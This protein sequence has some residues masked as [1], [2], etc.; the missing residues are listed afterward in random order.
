MIEG[1]RSI[2]N[3]GEHTVVGGHLT[4]GDEVIQFLTVK[5]DGLNFVGVLL[6]AVLGSDVE[7][8]YDAV[9]EFSVYSGVGD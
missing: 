3:E 2:H 7:R 5:V 8:F 6:F 1:N 9:V 4:V